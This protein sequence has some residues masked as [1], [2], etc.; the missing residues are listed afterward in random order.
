MGVAALVKAYDDCAQ[1]ASKSE[2]VN[3]SFIE[4]AVSIWT[5][6]FSIDAC[7]V[8]VLE[9]DG[10]FGDKSPFNGIVALQTI[11]YRCKRDF[12]IKWAVEAIADDVMNRVREPT[13]FVITFLRGKTK[14][15]KGYLD[16]LMVKYDFSIALLETWHSLLDKVCMDILSRISTSISRYRELYGTEGAV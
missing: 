8:R 12:Y 2:K 13:A 1:L 11:V 5:R 3:A 10:E 14:S 6:L 7:R 15:D 16:L 4:S 9:V